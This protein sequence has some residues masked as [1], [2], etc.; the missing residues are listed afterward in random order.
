L[1]ED[2]KENPPPKKEGKKRRVQLILNS[3]LKDDKR[4]GA[5]HQTSIKASGYRI[6]K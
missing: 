4:S 5:I 1:N 6:T 2:L 3:S